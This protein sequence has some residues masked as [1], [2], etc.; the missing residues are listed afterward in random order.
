MSCYLDVDG[1][2]LPT[3]ADVERELEALLR[4]VRNRPELD[5][6]AHAD[7]DRIAGVVRNG[8]DRSHARGLAVFS[9]ASAGLWEVLE[10]PM[11]VRNQLVVGQ[12]PA[13]TQLESM[14]R[15]FERMGVLLVDRQRARMF[16]FEW[17]ELVDHSERFDEL[18]RDFDDR[19]ERERGDVDDHVAAMQSRHLRHAA[20]VA[21]DVYQRDGFERLALA[22]PDELMGEVE[23]ALHPYLRER[24]CGRLH[25]PVSSSVDEVR[26]AARELYIQNRRARLAELVDRLRAEAHSGRRGAVGLP[27]VLAAVS[28]GRVDNL[29]VSAGFA[30]E[31]WRCQACDVLALVGRACPRCGEEMRRVDDVVAESISLAMSHGSQVEVCW[32]DADLDVLGRIG[33]LLRY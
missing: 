29:L 15:D 31:G 5:P 20:A 30:E 9:S 11:P 6:R 8:L 33:A 28:D 32:G 27:D 12:H 17:G 14:A 10:L 23:G 21:W 4:P 19:G 24:S 13:V 25:L 26:S 16:V 7:L 1:R 3:R 2:R 22:V 18:P